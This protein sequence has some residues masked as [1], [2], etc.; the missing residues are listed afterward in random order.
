M[1][2]PVYNELFADNLIELVISSRNS[3]VT[4]PPL[5]S[6]LSILGNAI[7]IEVSITIGL[8]VQIIFS[9]P[10]TSIVKS[11]IDEKVDMLL[12]DSR[13]VGE[14]MQKLSGELKKVNTNFI[15]LQENNKE[16]KPEGNIDNSLLRKLD[17]NNIKKAIAIITI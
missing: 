9:T 6:I 2:V 14:E 15:E 7:C 12:K 8:V 11:N 16:K 13:K 5:T 4:F 3:L 17:M 1:L 10:F